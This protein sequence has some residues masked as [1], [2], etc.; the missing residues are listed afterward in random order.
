MQRPAGVMEIRQNPGDGATTRLPAKMRRGLLTIGSRREAGC[1][2]GDTEAKKILVWPPDGP[3]GSQISFCG[4]LPS[5]SF[6]LD[7]KPSLGRHCE[8]PSSPDA[9]DGALSKILDGA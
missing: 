7:A 1:G 6:D 4:L 5:L 2:Q 3:P 8:V 9:H